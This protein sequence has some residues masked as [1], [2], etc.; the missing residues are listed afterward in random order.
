[1]STSTNKRRIPGGIGA[2]RAITAALLLAV[3]VSA[4]SDAG[5]NQNAGTT[6]AQF[7]KV[8]VTPR[9]AALG[10]AYGALG[11]DA[12]AMLYNP[13]GLH[14]L[15]RKEAQFVH[16]ELFAD[17]RLNSLFYAHPLS[18]PLGTIGV[19]YTYLDYGSIPRTVLVTSGGGYPIF[20][21]SGSFSA[22]DHALTLAYADE[23]TWWGRRFRWGLSAKVVQQ[24]IGSESSNGLMY[25]AGVLHTLPGSRIRLGAA[26][27]NLGFLSKFRDEADPVPIRFKFSAARPFYND[28]LRLAA[29]LNVPID[30]TPVLSLGAEVLPL[31]QL[32]LRAGYRWDND[33]SDFTGYSLGI[34]TTLAGVT[35]DYAYVPFELLGGNHRFSISSQFGP[36]MR[37]PEEVGLPVRRPARPASTPSTTAQ[38]PSAGIPATTV[39]TAPAATGTRG[40]HAE[41][42]VQTAGGP[43]HA[44]L[45]A[46]TAQ[47]FHKG[48]QRRGLL[49]PVS[50]L[51]VNGEYTVIGQKL[52]VTARVMAYG[53]VFGTFESDGDVSEPFLVW[54][55]LTESVNGR[56]ASLGVR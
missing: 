16:A 49:N 13:A 24:V 12:E 10:E 9:A 14:Y 23:V 27:Q 5:W 29:D 25:D 32:A 3:L 48:W 1:M 31:P 30:N 7:L 46:A 40:V 19:N 42:F 2:I 41:P 47:V 28:K 36:E 21:N 51:V 34:G 55:K 54:A 20:A 17:I 52:I 33:N 4:G 45:G 53:R 35:L 15:S 39:T 37:R 43:E 6:G 11:D 38:A 50:P 26:V 18:D 56:L 22:Y 44:W 8:A